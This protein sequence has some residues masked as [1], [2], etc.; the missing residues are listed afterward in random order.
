MSP[1]GLRHGTPQLGCCWFSPQGG[2]HHHYSRAPASRG[3]SLILRKSRED[4]AG[5][6]VSLLPV[7][8]ELV[9]G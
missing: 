1:Q 4:L 5:G 2:A 9:V 6:T 7:C 3:V 8:L